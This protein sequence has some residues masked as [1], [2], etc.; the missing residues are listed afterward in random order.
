ML[1]VYPGSDTAT[2]SDDVEA[3]IRAHRP[4]LDDGRLLSCHPHADQQLTEVVRTTTKTI[5]R[6]KARK[7][8]P[9]R[10]QRRGS[11]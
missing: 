8:Q 3:W 6:F 2:D 5:A 9:S 1:S 10:Q 7:P 11:A 4:A